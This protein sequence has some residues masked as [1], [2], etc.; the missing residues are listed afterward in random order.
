MSVR[1]DDTERG[2]RYTIGNSLHWLIKIEFPTV[3]P[4]SVEQLWHTL[5]NSSFFPRILAIKYICVSNF[6][7]LECWSA[8]YH[9]SKNKLRDMLV[10]VLENEIWV[11][12]HS[13][14]ISK[15]KEDL[16]R[17]DF[18]PL[19]RCFPCLI[20]NAWMNLLMLMFK[21]PKDGAWI[22]SI[23]QPTWHS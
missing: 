17:K 1:F 8:L 5:W 12:K 11:N 22:S 19:G 4:P 13:L 3:I 18:Y 15:R 9:F 23:V 7:F 21:V 20:V 6:P 2:M 10:K 16:L 14:A